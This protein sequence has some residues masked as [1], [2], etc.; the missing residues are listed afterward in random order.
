MD[1][2]T[3]GTRGESTVG[4]TEDGDAGCEAK[5]RREQ[6]EADWKEEE[7]Q[8]HIK[9]QNNKVNA[10]VHHNPLCIIEGRFHERL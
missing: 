4:V 9:V 8:H 5:V 2:L 10:H 3:G 1:C 7:E 6:F